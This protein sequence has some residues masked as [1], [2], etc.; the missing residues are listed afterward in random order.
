MDIHFSAGEKHLIICINFLGRLK[1]EL[2]TFQLATQLNHFQK[3]IVNEF[4]NFD[5]PD[6]DF[7]IRS[8]LLIAIPHPIYSE[9]TFHYKN[10]LYD[11]I[12]LVNSDF[13]STRKVVDN[14]AVRNKFHYIEASN[15]PLKRIAVQSGLSVYGRNNI[16]YIE[17]LGSCFSYIA[18]Y[19]DIPSSGIE[20]LPVRVAEICEKCTACMVRCPTKAIEKDSFVINNQRCLSYFNESADPFPE[21]LPLTVHHT[22]YDCLRCQI[23]CPMNKDQIKNKGKKIIFTEDEIDVLTEP[24]PR[25]AVRFQLYAGKRVIYNLIVLLQ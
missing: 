24:F 14:E 13:D 8:I 19:T 4:Y 9:V 5:L 22:L 2:L 7:D 11:C 20:W 1:S 23:V 15:L 21:W 25:K 18:Y 16:T 17:G 3:W 6:T 12:S 10:K